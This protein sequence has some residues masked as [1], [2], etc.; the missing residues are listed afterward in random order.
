MFGHKKKERAAEVVEAVQIEA[1]NVSTKQ[2]KDYLE[3]KQGEAIA[4]ENMLVEK[5]AALDEMFNVIRQES[6]AMNDSLAEFNEAFKGIKTVEESLN[7]TSEY[8]S[9][10]TVDGNEKVQDLHQSTS[11]L[12]D[13]FKVIGE[14]LSEFEKAFGEIKN[15]TSGIVNIATQ[16]NLLALNASIE[17]ARAGEAGRGFAVVA[18]EINN[19]SQETKNMVNQI[20]AAMEVVDKQAAKLTECFKEMDTTVDTNTLKVKET[21]EFVSSFEEVAEGLKA[22][23]TDTNSVVLSVNETILKL[24]GYVAQETKYYDGLMTSVT[25]LKTEL[26]GKSEA[27]F[28]DKAEI[29]GEEAEERSTEPVASMESASDEA[30]EETV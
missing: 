24:G 30:S 8:I 2:I 26:V 5:L 13:N 20:D 28:A 7:D 27:I 21:G 19:L 4:S 1:S 11:Q 29:L 23:A 12:A 18:G 10:V 14:V 15:Y 6:Q 9:K 3:K 25:E 17:A 22:R 16:T